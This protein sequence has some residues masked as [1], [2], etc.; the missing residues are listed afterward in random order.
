MKNFKFDNKN[1]CLVFDD[2]TS[3]YLIGAPLEEGYLVVA[4]KKTCFIDARSYLGVKDAL[5][6]KGVEV[7]LFK[8]I[9]FIKDFLAEIGTENLYLDFSKVSVK[10]YNEI[11]S[12]GFKIKDA[13]EFLNSLRAIKNEDEKNFSA[14]QS[15][16]Q[17]PDRFL[18]PYGY[19]C[20]TSGHQT[21]PSERPR[22]A[23]CLTLGKVT[24][25]VVP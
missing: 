5:I 11:L 7:R 22:P 23:H 17:T 3:E 13:E 24:V 4:D 14:L 15:A 18:C 2:L 25:S 12:F 1:A 21:P 6:K 9:S 8:T 19:P 16:P 10:K 20:R